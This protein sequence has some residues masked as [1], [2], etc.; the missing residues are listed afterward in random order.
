MSPALC[1]FLFHKSSGQSRDPLGPLP[2]LFIYFQL[3]I[4]FQWWEAFK[5]AKNGGD[6]RTSLPLSESL[7]ITARRH[8]DCGGGGSC[9]IA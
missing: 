5:G 8:D 3:L 6:V 9:V 7:Y 2:L 4:Y 1:T